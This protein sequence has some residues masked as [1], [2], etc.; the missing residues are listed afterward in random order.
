M[1]FC[2]KLFYSKSQS[3]GATSR[4]DA[5]I[6]AISSASPKNKPRKLEKSPKTAH[7]GRGQ[8]TKWEIPNN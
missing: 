8:E 1:S 5:M 2:K 6:S 4:F 7:A 3:H